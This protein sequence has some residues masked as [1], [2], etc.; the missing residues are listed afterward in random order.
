MN[1]QL[2]HALVTTAIVALIVWRLYGRIRRS[3]GRQ[4]LHPVRPWLTVTLFPLVL[5]LLAWAG[6]ARPLVE[7]SLWC[8]VAVGIGLG[9]LGHRLTRYEVTPEGLFYIPS[10]HLGVA[11]STVLVCRIVYRFVISGGPGAMGSAPPAQPLT[12]LTVL[13]IGTLAGYYVTYAVGLLRWAAQ[14]RRSG[15]PAAAD[16][17]RS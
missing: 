15:P 3:I 9:I 13:L 5:A 6:L 1:P 11:L 10:A 8:G 17:Q 7:G 14:A 2:T 16:A 12:P 4:R